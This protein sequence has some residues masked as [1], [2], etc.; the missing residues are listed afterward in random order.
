MNLML[1]I[2][3]LNVGVKFGFL[4]FYFFFQE[5]VFY[6]LGCNVSGMILDFGRSK[7]STALV[8][9]PMCFCLGVTI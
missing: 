9:C 4:I 5:W 1:V 2:M 6:A 8:F 7:G 3:Q